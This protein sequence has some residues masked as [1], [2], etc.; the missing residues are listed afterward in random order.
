[1]G[2]QAGQF[3]DIAADTVDQQQIVFDVA[4]TKALPIPLSG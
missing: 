2:V 4:I 3:E 1:M